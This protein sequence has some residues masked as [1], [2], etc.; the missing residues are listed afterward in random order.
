[1]S[2]IK[3]LCVFGILA[4]L[5]VE[6]RACKNHMGILVSQAEQELELKKARNEHFQ[7]ELDRLKS[8]ASLERMAK[9]RLGMVI[10]EP[11]AVSTLEDDSGKTGEPKPSWFERLLKKLSGH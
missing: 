6:E 10:P 3:W 2:P 9:E 4:A 5:L 8:T 11:D 1:M 7:L